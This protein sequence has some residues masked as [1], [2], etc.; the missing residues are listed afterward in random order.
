MI[1]KDASGALPVYPAGDGDFTI[2]G[3]GDPKEAGPSNKP[4]QTHPKG[5]MENGKES[6][7]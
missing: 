6:I 7:E 4:T 3:I 2:E 5:G 1:G